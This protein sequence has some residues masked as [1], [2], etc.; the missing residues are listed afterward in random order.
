MIELPRHHRFRDFNWVAFDQG[1][2]QTLPQV[3]FYPAGLLLTVTL[4]DFFLQLVEVFQAEFPGEFIVELGQ[5]LF[6]DLLQDDAEDS[7]LAP[8]APYY[9]NSPGK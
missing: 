6:L 1:F 8:P 5:D 3:A 9:H 4:G 2:H 7:R